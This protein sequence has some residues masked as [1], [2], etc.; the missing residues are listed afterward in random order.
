MLNQKDLFVK[1]LMVD[2]TL[3]LSSPDRSNHLTLLIVKKILWSTTIG[4]G[5]SRT[6]VFPPS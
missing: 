6:S 5:W 3:A 4:K 1:A 2:K